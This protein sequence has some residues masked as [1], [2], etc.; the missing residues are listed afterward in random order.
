MWYPLRAKLIPNNIQTFVYLLQNLF[1]KNGLSKRILNLQ[2]FIFTL[3]T[4]TSLYQLSLLKFICQ[5]F[6][7]IPFTALKVKIFYSLT[8]AFPFW[9]E[10]QYPGC[11][12]EP[13]EMALNLKWRKA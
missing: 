8:L 5:Y 9:L 1:F 10:I 12:I 7:N 3:I 11:H 13:R 6:K 4:I 2:I